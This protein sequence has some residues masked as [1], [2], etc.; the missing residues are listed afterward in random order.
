MK[1]MQCR[2]VDASID[3]RKQEIP[4][5]GT[6]RMAHLPV[7]G[8]VRLTKFPANFKKDELLALQAQISARFSFQ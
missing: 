5:V 1:A 2:P 6:E 8:T 3:D 7:D 4:L